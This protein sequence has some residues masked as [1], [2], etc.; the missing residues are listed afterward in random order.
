MGSA[1]HAYANPQQRP[2]AR[3]RPDLRVVPGKGRDYAAQVGVSPLFMTCFKIVIAAI[4]FLAAIGVCRVWLTS[5][6]VSTLMSSEELSAQ[7]DDAQSLAKDLEVQQAVLENPTRIEDYATQYLA[8]VPAE[9]TD[10]IDVSEGAVA[11]DSSGTL[12]LSGSLASLDD[13]SSDTYLAEATDPT[14]SE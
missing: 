4:L 14:V 6:T 11:T 1:A 3:P 2:A 12:S 13:A 9:E 7:I 8:M 5:A 10:Y